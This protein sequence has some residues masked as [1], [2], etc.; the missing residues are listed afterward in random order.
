MAPPE[1]P[2]SDCPVLEVTTQLD[3][4]E[5]AGARRTWMSQQEQDRWEAVYSHL[6][7][8]EQH[9]T[10]QLQNQQ[11][12]NSAILNVNGLILGFLGLAGLSREA[13]DWNLWS[14]RLFIAA[15]A[16]LAFALL[17]GLAS[18]KP[19]IR[20]DKHDWLDADKVLGLARPLEEV[21]KTLATWL[22]ESQAKA[23]H[24]RTLRRRRRLMFW[25]IVFIVVGL[26][27]VAAALVLLFLDK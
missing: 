2:A 3:Q 5:V 13:P 11:Q 25:E 17:L 20:I 16:V 22:Q 1:L 19:R 21:F 6:L 27:V 26:V 7:R 23:H 10:D 14:T 4:A 15:L 18:M 8:I 24:H 9:W 12:R